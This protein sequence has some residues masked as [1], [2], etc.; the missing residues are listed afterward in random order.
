MHDA[1][2]PTTSLDTSGSVENSRTL[3]SGPDS[4][5]ARNASLTS[6]TLA[7]VLSTPVKSVSE[8]SGV[9]TRIDW[10]SR[11]P[12]IDSSTRPVARAAP[13]DDGTML[14][15]AARARRRSLWGPST[16]IWSPVYEWIVVMRPLS[17]PNASSSTLIIGTKQLVVHE[18]F[19]TTFWVAGS[20]VSSL[21]PTT[22]VPSAPDDGADT[23]TNG[24][25]PSR[26]NAALSRLVKM[27]VDSTTTSTPRSPH[28][29]SLGSR[30]ASTLSV[31]PSTLMPSSV[32]AMS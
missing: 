32:A 19:D 7:S 9:G 5:A 14:M 11:R 21:T 22:K 4:A 23:T 25:P 27:P 2:E 16:S 3:A 29:S 18:A 6:S 31:S 26:W 12:C 10:P 28:G 30:T 1:G 8:P 20:N 15:A 13:V 24:A 17:T